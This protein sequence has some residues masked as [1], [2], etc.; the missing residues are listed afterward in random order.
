MTA[1][2]N[3]ENGW[4]QSNFTSINDINYTLVAFYFSKENLFTTFLAFFS[5]N[6]ENDSNN[7]NDQNNSI[8]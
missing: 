5:L 7:N 8:H 2:L 6:Y 1:F 4:R 3:N